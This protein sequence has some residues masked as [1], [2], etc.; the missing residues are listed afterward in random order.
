M[1]HQIP[2]VL[3]TGSSLGE[4][5]YPYAVNNFH[6]SYR[7]HNLEC[8]YS[9]IFAQFQ[10]E[11]LKIEREKLMQALAE[12]Q[13]RQE[14]L[15]EKH[16]CDLEVKIQDE[17]QKLQDIQEREKQE[18]QD[19]IEE[20]KRQALVM[21][22]STR[23][24][25]EKSLEQER[26]R[27][28]TTLDVEKEKLEISLESERK[29][30]LDLENR[31]ETSLVLQE[32]QHQQLNMLKSTKNVQVTPG[33]NS[34]SETLF[35]V[36]LAEIMSLQLMYQMQDLSRACHVEAPQS[37]D[38]GCAE[39]D[40]VMLESVSSSLLEKGGLILNS[41]R[42]KQRR[43]SR[44]SLT[45]TESFRE[46]Y[47]L[48]FPSSPSPKVSLGE[49]QKFQRSHSASLGSIQETRSELQSDSKKSVSSADILMPSSQD[50]KKIPPTD[51]F[52]VTTQD[53]KRCYFSDDQLLSSPQDSEKSPSTDDS[54]T[55]PNSKKS[56]STDD[57][58]TSQQSRKN[59]S[60]GVL[61]S[62]SQDHYSN[63]SLESFCENEPLSPR[64]RSRPSDSGCSSQHSDS[65]H[66]PGSKGRSLA[67]DC[68]RYEE[69]ACVVPLAEE[70]DE[71][72]D[73]SDDVMEDDEQIQSLKKRVVYLGKDLLQLKSEL[74]GETIN[75]FSEAFGV[76]VPFDDRRGVLQ[77]PVIS[78]HERGVCDAYSVRMFVRARSKYLYECVR[79][80]VCVCMCVRACLF[81]CLFVCVFIRACVCLCACECVCVCVCVWYANHAEH[82]LVFSSRQ[83]CPK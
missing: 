32:E 22:Q 67:I 38:S 17:W 47:L 78:V 41:L 64:A 63:S 25:L 56:P 9:L 59:Y 69:L 13:R 73:S 80:C 49:E 34:Q 61:M 20:E 39:Y 14:I 65:D 35:N 12:E 75:F 8:L 58:V 5:R 48:Q 15:K 51:D 76:D 82:S 6:F 11:V 29:R 45:S 66:S 18:S 19:A 81:V 60:P 55:S 37:C 62:F 52:F 72:L 2:D 4:S 74:D 42:D 27:V 71:D 46:L 44:V 16:K 43:E 79:A 53:S 24:E 1:Y 26:R 23:E 50:P 10:T 30:C 54:M 40:D 68:R 70:E 21:E 77:F 83:T 7:L 33:T 28:E 36:L 3:S 31:L 57:P